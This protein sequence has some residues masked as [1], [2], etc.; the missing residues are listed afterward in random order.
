MP[1]YRVKQYELHVSEYVVEAENGQDAIEKVC[2]GDGN[3]VSTEFICVDDTR[4]T[5]LDATGL[6]NSI[7]KVEEIIEE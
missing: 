3:L 7:R 5:R 1:K 4:G 6:C 2:N